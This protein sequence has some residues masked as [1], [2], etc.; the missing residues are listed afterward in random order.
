[1]RN[2]RCVSD[3]NRPR[4]TELPCRGNAARSSDAYRLADHLDSSARRSGADFQPVGQRTHQRKPATPVPRRGR[5]RA[6]P[7]PI[8]HRH[9]HAVDVI[10]AR[11]V[12]HPDYDLAAV[13]RA[14]LTRTRRIRVLD[15]VC[16]HLVGVLSRPAK[17]G[18]P[19]PQAA[20]RLAWCPHV[21]RQPDI[22]CVHAISSHRPG[23]R[24][25]S[26]FAY[27][28][29]SHPAPA[30]HPIGGLA[31]QRAC[32]AHGRCGRVRIPGPRRAVGVRPG[33]Q[34]AMFHAVMAGCG[35]FG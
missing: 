18:Q 29:T 10:R 25:H 8:S 17:L 4:I 33:E 1:M 13:G 24:V 35:P 30:A 23:R 11:H 15:R 7:P 9:N 20:P 22:Q 12:R 27:P 14:L 16:D 31:T 2:L 19:S 28:R 32:P 5:R 26:A 34:L 6:P 3:S 21:R